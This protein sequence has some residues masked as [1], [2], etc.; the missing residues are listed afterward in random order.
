MNIFD[1][2]NLW[3]IFNYKEKRNF[4]IL[5]FLIGILAILQSAGVLSILPFMYVLM[6]PTII[7]TNTIISSLKNFLKIEND[8]NILI[9]LGLFSIFSLFISNFFSIIVLYLT[10]F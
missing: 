7:E 1:L 8:Q 4:S 9:I 2:I 5:I 3:K 10:T 6:N